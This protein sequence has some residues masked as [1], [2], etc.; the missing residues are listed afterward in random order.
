MTTEETNEL[1]YGIYKIYWKGGGH[2]LGAVGGLHNGKRWLALTNWTSKTA[3]GIATS[4]QKI[5]NLI[6][7]MVL[8]CDSNN[9]FSEDKD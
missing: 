1:P 2:T 7:K 3:D 4:K 5:W 6:R 9:F 8:V